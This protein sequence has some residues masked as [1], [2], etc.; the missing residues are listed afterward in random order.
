MAF[1]LPDLP[2]EYDALEP[3]IDERTM[4]IHHDKHYAGYTKKLNN[5]LED[6]PD[7]QDRSV[8]D[9]LRNLDDLRVSDA[10]RLAIRQNGGG[11]INHRLF[12]EIMGPEKDIDEALVEEIEENFGSSPKFK[13]EF[14]SAAS[15]QFG[16]GWAWLVRSGDELVVYSTPNQDSPYL[17]GDTPLIGLDVWEHAYYLKYQNERGSYIDEW[18]KVLKLLP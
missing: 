4:R 11:F 5:A 6:Y 3:V 10:D 17:H 7:L 18:F 13:E 9:L 15:G 2:Y 12:W 8:E 1:T 16:S 14:A